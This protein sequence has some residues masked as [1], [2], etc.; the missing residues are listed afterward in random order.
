[1]LCDHDHGFV[2][3]ALPNNGQGYQVYFK[4]SPDGDKHKAAPA[5]ALHAA[6][7]SFL[8][9]QDVAVGASLKTPKVT[10]IIRFPFLPEAALQAVYR[11]DSVQA[12]QAALRTPADSAVGQHVSSAWD[13]CH[14]TGL[15]GEKQKCVY[16]GSDM[17]RFAMSALGSPA[18]S[19]EVFDVAANP[20][21]GD[22]VIQEVVPVRKCMHGG[23]VVVCHP[24]HYPVGLYY[25]HSIPATTLSMV[26]LSGLN[27]QYIMSCHMDTSHFPAE[28]MAFTM[29]G[30]KPGD[31]GI[32]HWLNLNAIGFCKYQPALPVTA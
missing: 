11:A 1:M 18:A 29:T 3:G 32:C 5:A 6:A 25:C 30:T 16:S 4:F 28:H 31:G 17:L 9:S 20:P 12:I 24:H 14:Q 2:D 15:P 22:F 8:K 26:K 7:G 19:I 21:A 13:Y 27:M 23:P 10:P